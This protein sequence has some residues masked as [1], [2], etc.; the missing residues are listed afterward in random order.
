MQNGRVGETCSNNTQRRKGVLPVSGSRKPFV[1][2]FKSVKNR[3]KTVKGPPPKQQAARGPRRGGGM[4]IK[5]RKSEIDSEMVEIMQDH[6]KHTHLYGVVHEDLFFD[7]TKSHAVDGMLQR[8][9]RG[10]TITLEVT[11]VEE[12]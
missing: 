2:E 4:N 7:H 12:E 10:E 8:M 5:C 6:R 1:F 11:L 9:N 3:F